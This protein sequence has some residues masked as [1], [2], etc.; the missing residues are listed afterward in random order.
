[1]GYKN[2]LIKLALNKTPSSVVVWLVNKKLKGIAKLTH[3]NFDSAERNLLVKL[4]FVGEDEPFDV[5]FGSFTLFSDEEPYKLVIEQVRSS[6]PWVD[7]LLTRLVLNKKLRI[8]K[9]KSEL[10]KKLFD[11]QEIE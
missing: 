11:N 3:F 1:M 4:K 7:A 8:P 10:I 5:C 6:K 2:S 9:S